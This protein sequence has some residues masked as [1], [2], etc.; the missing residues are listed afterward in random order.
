MLQIKKRE[1]EREVWKVLEFQ[2][3]TIILLQ[4]LFREIWEFC[5][6]FCYIYFFKIAMR[7]VV[8]TSEL[9]AYK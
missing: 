6:L 4:E 1:R 8:G 3:D 9:L 5:V 2:E 7:F